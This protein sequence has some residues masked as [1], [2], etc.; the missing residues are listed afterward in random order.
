MFSTPSVPL[1][2]HQ[3]S[4]P[5]LDN[6]RTS[7]GVDGPVLISHIRFNTLTMDSDPF[8]TASPLCTSEDNLL[9]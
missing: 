1:M 5:S 8:S 9:T 2:A 4:G 6:H 7:V 3:L